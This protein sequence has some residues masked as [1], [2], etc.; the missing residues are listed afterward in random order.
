MQ[1]WWCN[2]F[3]ELQEEAEM[4]GWDDMVSDKWARWAKC[5]QMAGVKVVL[6]TE[7]DKGGKEAGWAEVTRDLRRSRWRVE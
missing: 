6:G 2:S 7:K 4:W 1:T 5:L 3:Q